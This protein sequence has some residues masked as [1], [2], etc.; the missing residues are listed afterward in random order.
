MEK[1]GI[2]NSA[3]YLSAFVITYRNKILNIGMKDILDS[4]FK[5]YNI[6]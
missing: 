2:K 5:A 6:S 4:D 3:S 1:S